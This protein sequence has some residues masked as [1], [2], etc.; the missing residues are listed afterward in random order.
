[1]VFKFVRKDN[2][3]DVLMNYIPRDSD[4]TAQTSSQKELKI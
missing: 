4:Q 2:S 3:T 1:M